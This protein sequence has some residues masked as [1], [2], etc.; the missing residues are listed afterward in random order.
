MKNPVFPRNELN[1]A[2]CWCYKI[3]NRSWKYAVTL[4]LVFFLASCS[5]MSFSEKKELTAWGTEP[6]TSKTPSVEWLAPEPGDVKVIDDV[7]FIYASNRRYMFS[8]YEP[9]Y[10]WMKKDEYTPRMGENLLTRNSEEEKH[11]KELEERI[12]RLEEELR[13]MGNS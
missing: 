11:L 4:L 12:K 1:M 13:K 7:E 6:K 9:L 3:P 2:L 10:V 8:P 5:S